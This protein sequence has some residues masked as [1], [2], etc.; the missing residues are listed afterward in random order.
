MESIYSYATVSSNSSYNIDQVLCTSV[1]VCAIILTLPSLGTV[2]P[3]ASRD[4]ICCIG[5]QNL[6]NL[7][8]ISRNRQLRNAVRNYVRRK[9]KR[10]IE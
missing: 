9:L 1:Y 2:L 8:Q 3:L 6:D 7:C 10:L 5:L 4:V